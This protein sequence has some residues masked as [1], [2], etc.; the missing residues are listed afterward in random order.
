MRPSHADVCED[1]GGEDAGEGDGEE[2]GEEEREV[3]DAEAVEDEEGEAAEAREE[4]ADGA[5]V[6]DGCAE[7]LGD[8]GLWDEDGFV[9]LEDGAFLGIAFFLFGGDG[10]DEESGWG[11]GHGEGGDEIAVGVFVL[12]RCQ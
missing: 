5:E 6:E 8:G 9:V 7:G 2:E 12:G 10:L 11:L 4:A 3:L 1:D